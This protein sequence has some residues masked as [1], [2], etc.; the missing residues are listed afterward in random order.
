MRACPYRQG[1]SLREETAPGDYKC[2]LSGKPRVVNSGDCAL[3]AKYG[4]MAL[5]WYKG[6]TERTPSNREKSGLAKRGKFKGG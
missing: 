5:T 3:C 6:Q 1:I 4:I 2:M